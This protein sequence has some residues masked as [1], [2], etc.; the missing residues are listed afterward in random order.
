MRKG[1]AYHEEGVGVFPSAS[2]LRAEIALREG[3]DGLQ[4]GIPQECLQVLEQGRN[5]VFPVV[6][7]D[8]SEMLYYAVWDHMNELEEYVDVS[9]ELA[10][11]IRNQWDGF[12]NWEEFAGILK[13]KQYTLTRIQRC[14]VHILLGIKQAKR[15]E[16]GGVPRLDYEI[17]PYLRVL[18]FRDF[19]IKNF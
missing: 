12:T 3:L 1:A 19:L 8:F 16:G 18:G 10:D 17:A 5:H 9:T 15:Q 2:G 14:L 4:V 6:T 11:R 13:T 7:N